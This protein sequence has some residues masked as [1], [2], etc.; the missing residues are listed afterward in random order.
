M[1]KWFHHLLNPHCEHC[2]DE[3]RE[4]RVCNSCEVLKMEVARLQI[5]NSRLLGRLLEKPEPVAD[6]LIAP[7]LDPALLPRPTLSWRTRQQ[8]LE[9]AD[10]DKAKAI[11]T[12]KQAVGQNSRALSVSELEKEL[13][14]GPE[15]GN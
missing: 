12:V 14:V 1:I 13:Q 9:Q 2:A 3:L 10:R 4:S 7:D 6:R 11:N 15:E 8:M 5:E